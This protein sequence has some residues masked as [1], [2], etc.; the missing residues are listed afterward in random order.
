[1][2][3]FDAKRTTAASALDTSSDSIFLPPAA[4]PRLIPDGRILSIVAQ[5][6]PEPPAP[7]VP[8]PKLPISLVTPKTNIFAST[9]REHSPM[10]ISFKTEDAPSTVDEAGSHLQFRSA[11]KENAELRSARVELQKS[12]DDLK[13]LVGERQALV[14]AYE[15]Y[16]DR[17]VKENKLLATRQ[18]EGDSSLSKKLQDIESQN[19]KIMENLRATTATLSENEKNYITK[20]NSLFSEK[21]ALEA[22]VSLLQ[23]KTQESLVQQ[24]RFE[25]LKSQF[26]TM[27]SELEAEK[28]ERA[29]MLRQLELA[30]CDV[31]AAKQEILR[32]ESEL[33]DCR[34][35]RDSQLQGLT[36]KMEQLIALVS[37][38]EQEIGKL[39]KELI[40]SSTSFQSNLTMAPS[41]KI[42]VEELEAVKSKNVELSQRLE[43]LT[44]KYEELNVNGQ[45]N[46]RLL[47]AP[48][49]AGEVDLPKQNPFLSSEVSVPHIEQL[50]SGRV[51]EREETR[52]LS[53]V[54]QTTGAREQFVPPITESNESNKIIFQPVR[55]VAHT[56]CAPAPPAPPR[57]VSLPSSPLSKSSQ[58]PPFPPERRPDPLPPQPVRA[59]SRP[60][61]QTVRHCEYSTEQSPSF[62]FES[63][64][65]RSSQYLPPSEVRT[66]RVSRVILNGKVIYDQP[67]DQGPD[68]Q[69]IVA[70]RL[71]SM[72]NPVK[73]E[74]GLQ[75]SQ[76]EN[77]HPNR[78]AP[79][80]EYTLRA[81][82]TV[83]SV[84]CSLTNN[85]GGLA[86]NSSGRVVRTLRAQP[87]SEYYLK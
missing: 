87:A 78:R 81:E 2:I 15:D 50:G 67:S 17:L 53:A 44:R 39:K 12:K 66:E 83:N 73:H 54:A 1:M 72:S 18:Q 4:A 5:D 82:S 20:I 63:M 32:L 61:A 16:I 23:T 57:T 76:K 68:C 60:V 6:L 28:E 21:Q 10:D 69:R 41:S 65:N 62:H 37:S 45:R 30:R 29:K 80:E 27:Q 34:A 40:R 47:N 31:T 59:E 3:K 75:L 36:K 19:T 64:P 71:R 11:Q 51:P 33:A 26:S 84:R 56:H 13:A 9:E 85:S 25:K 49:N 77:L 24:T 74:L 79:D 38:K 58:K 86:H 14:Q 22:Q 55:Q 8:L 35:L 48:G 70:S 46:W 42:R 7:T 52:P 43:E